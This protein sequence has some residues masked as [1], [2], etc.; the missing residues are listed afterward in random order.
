M[1]GVKI[2][3]FLLIPIIGYCQTS[4]LTLNDIK[5]INSEEMFKKVMMER[6]LVRDRE[7][8]DSEG[9]TVYVDDKS[10]NTFN[11][12]MF[13]LIAM[14]YS[15]MDICWMGFDSN[16][17]ILENEYNDLFDKV[18]SECSYDKID[19]QFYEYIKYDCGDGFKIGFGKEEDVLMINKYPKE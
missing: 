19:K 5:S 2:L 8:E 3:I 9:K 10:S 6:G 18:K 15:D 1:G 12:E 13:K 14:Y 11:E 16:T 7:K 17:E 4:K